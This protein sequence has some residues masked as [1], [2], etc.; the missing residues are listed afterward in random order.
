MTHLAVAMGLF[1]SVVVAAE[2]SLTARVEFAA[3]RYHEHPTALDGLYQELTRAA[4]GARRV[5]VLVA[6]ARVAFVWGDARATT[7]DQKLAA[8]DRG[9]GAARRALE[10]DGGSA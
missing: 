2:P 10:L 1:A 3:T 6:L 7:T 4:E 5:D 8:Y 9:Q